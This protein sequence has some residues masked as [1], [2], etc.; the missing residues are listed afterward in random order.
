MFVI[1]KEFVTVVKL[2]INKLTLNSIKFIQT[3]TDEFI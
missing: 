3:L 2:I 1:S